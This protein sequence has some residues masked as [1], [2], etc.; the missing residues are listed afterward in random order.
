MICEETGEECDPKTN[1]FCG[2]TDDWCVEAF[3]EAVKNG[4]QRFNPFKD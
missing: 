4:V 3:A 2:E 1:P